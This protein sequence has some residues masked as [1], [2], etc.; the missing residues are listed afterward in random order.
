MINRMTTVRVTQIFLKRNKKRG[1]SPVLVTGYSLLVSPFAK[2]SG[3]K[4]HPPSCKARHPPAPTPGP[5]QTKFAWVDSGAVGIS[6][7]PSRAKFPS[8]GG[9]ERVSVTGW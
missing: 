8:V 5:A 1:E 4:P 2:A 6:V 3:D 7:F 9:M